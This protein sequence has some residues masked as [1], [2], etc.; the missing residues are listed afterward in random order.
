MA[1]RPGPP[2]VDAMTRS[3]RYD[4]ALARYQMSAE[5]WL[6]GR[7][8]GED[9]DAEVD[10]LRRAFRREEKRDRKRAKRQR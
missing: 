9:L 6:Q 7:L 8:T 3:F 2:T 10:R 5:R 1:V 4:L